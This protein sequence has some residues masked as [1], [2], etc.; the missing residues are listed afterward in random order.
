[1]ISWL[2]SIKALI[3]GGIGI[4]SF[5]F[6]WLGLLE[7]SASGGICIVLF[8]FISQLCGEKYPA[9]YKKVIWFLITLRLCIPIN[10]SLLP[11]AFTVKLPV[12]VLGE[13]VNSGM[14]DVANGS[15]TVGS[16]IVATNEASDGGILAEKAENRG[17]NAAVTGTANRQITSQSILI[18]FWGCGCAMVILYYLLGHIIFCRKM[19]Q[20]S[21]SC[22]NKN[23]L[24]TT[25]KLSN[26]LG[27]KKI[28]EVRLTSDNQTGPYTVGFF[29]NI[30]VL[31]NKDYH[32]KDLKYIIRHELVHCVNKDTQLKVLFVMINAIHWFNPLVWFMKTLVDQDMELACDE[33]VL[34]AASKEERSEY[35]EV[36]MSC[37]GTSK[38]GSAT[39]STGYVHGVKF[40]KKRFSNIFHTQKKIGKAVACIIV[41]LLAAASGLIG[42]EAGRTV[43][44]GRRIEIDCGIEL[45]T[46]VTGDG[47]PDQIRVYDDNDV[48]RT[49]ITLTSADGM[50]AQFDYNEE[51]WASSYLVTGDLSGN[52]AAD[53]V[54]MRISNGMHGDGPVSVLHVVQEQDTGK[55][56]WQEYPNTFIHNPTIGMEQPGTFD[57]IACLGATVIE[58]SGRHL[59]RLIALDMV[60]FD[61]DTVQCIDCSLQ[62]GGW[63]IENMQTIEGYYSENKYKEVLRNNIFYLTG[64]DESTDTETTEADETASFLTN[65]LE[66]E[67]T[68]STDISKYSQYDDF[69][70]YS[71]LSI[72]PET[73]DETKV[74]DYLY[75]Y[76][77]TFLDPT[78]EIYLEYCYEGEAYQAELERLQGI[79]AEHDGEVQTIIYDTESFSYP[80]YVTI[81]ANNHCYEYALLL[82]D[83][84]IAYIFLQFIREEEVYFPADYLPNAYE[85][86]DQ[87]YSMYIFYKETLLGREG[88]CIY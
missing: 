47:L 68:V 31:P 19:L 5:F 36:L 33:K 39:L 77:D 41:A 1:M 43:Y 29:R 63:Y 52:G 34:S 25:I 22:T 3:L 37:I 72:F 12:Y 8:F 13:R 83:G 38:I 85:A 27:L 66:G 21:E 53:I 54:L 49:S 65:L 26:E 84:K 7:A 20:R 50:E 76:E 45:R 82:G 57:D 81:N 11:Q 17:G 48:L 9:K 56:V 80:A 78:A 10:F 64:D 30:I 62:D 75:R 32:E 55:P 42:F 14:A 58:K 87:G 35:S 28:P 24:A 60:V 71:T 23:I 4:A 40:I 74:I 69:R 2:G 16:E 6:S 18:A 46:D 59:L 86:E 70:G 79:R 88:Y 67:K 44:A 51:L 61:D 73:V 15:F